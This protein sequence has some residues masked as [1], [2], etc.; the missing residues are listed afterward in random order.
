MNLPSGW[1]N[2][3]FH[4]AGLLR[5]ND[6]G[7]VSCLFWDC[8]FNHDKRNQCYIII[9]NGIC[10]M[11]LFSCRCH[12]NRK[13]IP[14]VTQSTFQKSL[15]VNL[16]TWLRQNTANSTTSRKSHTSSSSPTTAVEGASVASSPLPRRVPMRSSRNQCYINLIWVK[17]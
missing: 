17:S 2:S 11:M 13:S 14:N 16:S 15:R 9:I 4:V 3:K 10:H 7:F 1:C 8:P 12:G 6:I 5:S